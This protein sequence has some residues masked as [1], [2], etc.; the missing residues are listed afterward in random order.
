MNPLL[1]LRPHIASI[2]NNIRNTSYWMNPPGKLPSFIIIGAQKA[3]TTALFKALS[4]HP[5]ISTARM[6]EVHFANRNWH[7]G[8][9]WYARCFPVDA[10]CAFECTPD[11]LFFPHA[12]KRMSAILSRESK[13]I[14]LLRDPV[15]RAL[16]HHQYETLRGGETKRF[17]D[18]LALEQRRTDKAWEKAVYADGPWTFSLDRNSY[19]RRGLYGMHLQNWIN[20]VG[21]SRLLV[22]EDQELFQSPESTIKKILNFLCL[23]SSV[24]LQF[25]LENQGKYRESVSALNDDLYEFFR[26]DAS[27]LWKQWGRD[28]SWFDLY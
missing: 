9:E 23:D 13:F 1:R 11:Y 7:R 19:M 20:E 5:Q 26:D 28:F 6:K 25:K 21:Q 22:L 3:G 24:S 18:A 8:V 14:A 27:L 12:A 16:S 17:L 10:E 15:K 2:A 4:E